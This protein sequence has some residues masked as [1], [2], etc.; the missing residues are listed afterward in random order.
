MYRVAQGL[1]RGM[2]GLGLPKIGG[3]GSYLH[4]DH[5]QHLGEPLLSEIS[6]RNP[7]LDEVR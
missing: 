6:T 1:Y 5:V 4:K 2:W 7:E 3:D